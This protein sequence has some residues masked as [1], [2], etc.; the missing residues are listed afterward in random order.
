MV[1]SLCLFEGGEMVEEFIINVFRE[2]GHWLAITG[3]DVS[4]ESAVVGCGATPK[5][6]LKE[7][8]SNMD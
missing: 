3:V 6:A 4:D 1:F 5:E 7:L 2:D 8:L